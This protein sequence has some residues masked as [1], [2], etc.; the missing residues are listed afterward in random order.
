MENTNPALRKL[1]DAERVA[2]WTQRLVSG[3]G[4]SPEAAKLI[5]DFAQ[6]AKTFEIDSRGNLKH[7]GGIVVSMFIRLGTRLLKADAVSEED[8]DSA[9]GKLMRYF[10]DKPLGDTVTEWRTKY[11]SNGIQRNAIDTYLGFAG[12]RFNQLSSEEQMLFNVR[13]AAWPSRKEEA[14]GTGGTFAERFAIFA[15]AV[16]RLCTVANDSPQILFGSFFHEKKEQLPDWIREGE[17][18]KLYCNEDGC[19]SEVT[20]DSK[21]NYICSNPLCDRNIAA[22]GSPLPASFTSNMPA[23][24]S[25]EAPRDNGGNR[26]RHHD[27]DDDGQRQFDKKRNKP[28]GPRF[29]V[30]EDDEDDGG[31]N[32]PQTPSAPSVAT[33][34]GTEKL[35]NLGD[36]FEAALGKVK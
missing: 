2:E 17:D 19:N 26:D 3:G 7:A 34:P 18:G 1:T 9:V 13:D 36:A 23:P 24:R 30:N 32:V 21:G 25:A 6:K 20:T 35:G 15:K 4:Y 5:T 14:A 11:A 8:V 10:G 28:K 22:A 27:D 16:A 31:S 12:R 29:R 33:T